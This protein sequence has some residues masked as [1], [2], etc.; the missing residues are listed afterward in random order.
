[1]NNLSSPQASEEISV[2]SNEEA[3]FDQLNIDDL[4]SNV[5]PSSHK[6]ADDLS[7]K[8]TVLVVESDHAYNVAAA[9]NTTPTGNETIPSYNNGTPRLVKNLMYSQERLPKRNRF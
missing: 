3:F 7:T 8:N 9:D 4:M 1:M 2:G 5:T 6:N